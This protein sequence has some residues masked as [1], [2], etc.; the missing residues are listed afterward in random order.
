MCNKEIDIRVA[1][2]S[3]CEDI[4][5]WR[6]DTFS[7]SMFINSNIPSYE[8]HIDWFNS[9]LN[10]ADSEL[11]IGEV[12]STKIGICRFDR[13]TKS[14]LVEVS[15]NLNPYSRGLGYG[16]RLL[17]YSIECFQKIQKKELLAKIKPKNLASLKIFKSLGFK[18]VSLK[19]DI[20]TLVKSDKKISFK[21]VDQN[22]SEVL[23]KLLRER[24]HS[25]SHN[26]IP[27][28][29]E[30]NAFVKVHPYRHWA[31]VLEDDFP[32]GTFYLQDDNSVGLN[33]N[34][35]SLHIVSQVLIYIRAKFKPLREMKSKVPPYFYVNASYVNEKLGELLINSD[36]V[37]IQVSYQI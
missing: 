1:N 26:K 21:E 35:P 24:V 36:A 16:K 31:I 7:R 33:I 12:G 19:D 22:D 9:S 23:F 2:S 32:I 20:I 34:E 18:E 29:D 4:Y 5:V 13:N 10:N 28:W 8:E 25:I 14:G 11:Y 15:I 6:S 37:P 17:A 3:D 27:E 30:H